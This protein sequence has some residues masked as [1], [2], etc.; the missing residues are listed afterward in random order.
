MENQ[1]L[2]FL[3]RLNVEVETPSNLVHPVDPGPDP[4]PSF[5]E[6]LDSHINDPEPHPAYDEDIP[7]LSLIFENGLT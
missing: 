7:S 2:E 6:A 5:Q 4:D 1:A 3:W